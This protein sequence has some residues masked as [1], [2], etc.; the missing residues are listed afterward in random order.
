MGKAQQGTPRKPYTPPALVV[1]GN[2]HKLTHSNHPLG[3]KDTILRGTK[4]A[5]RG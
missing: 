2:V 1:Y 5:I 4:T 3:T